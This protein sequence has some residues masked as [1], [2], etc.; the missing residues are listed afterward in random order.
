MKVVVANDHVA[1]DMKLA[2]VEHL[3]ERGHEVHDLG[4]HSRE[5]TDYPVWGSRAARLVASG[6]YERGIVICGTGVGISISANKVDG[7]RCACVSEPYTARLS[8][9]HNDSN[10]LAFGARVVG[11]DVAKMIVDEWMA[12]EYE[13]GRHA[14]RVQQ[15]AELEAGTEF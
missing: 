11:V 12:G 5:R 4:A 9:Q 3:R 7:I 13:A 8:R 14:M 2:I 15:L 10:M 1:V 6:E